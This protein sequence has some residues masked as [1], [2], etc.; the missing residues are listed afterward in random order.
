MKI[1]D[2]FFHHCDHIYI[3]IY[4]FLFCTSMHV[5]TY[6][7]VCLY[8]IRGNFLYFL[9]VHRLFSILNEPLFRC[10]LSVLS[11]HFFLLTVYHFSI[12]LSLGFSFH[13][14]ITHTHTHARTCMKMHTHTWDNLFFLVMFS[15]FIPSIFSLFQT[16][17]SIKKGLILELEHPVIR[18]HI[19]NIWF[20]FRKRQ[21]FKF[22]LYFVKRHAMFFWLSVDTRSF[23]MT[24]R[25]LFKIHSH[26]TKTLK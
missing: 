2:S 4:I 20:L 12:S 19:L 18:I 13:H 7:C 22:L 6:V 23:S 9:L 25:N 26:E 10:Y 17:S 5:Y 1:D 24:K 15:A 11:H 14:N 8:P 16:I 3:Y 21:A